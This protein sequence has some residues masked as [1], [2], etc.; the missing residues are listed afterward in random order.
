[1]SYIIDRRLNAKQKSAVNRSRFLRRYRDHIKRAV[2]EAI[3]TRSITDLETGESV[4]IPAKDIHEPTIGHGPGGVRSRV[5]PGNK[6]FLSG[7]HIA[8]PEGGGA[9]G[10][11]GDASDSGEGEDDFVFRITHEEFL[12]YLFDNLELPHLAKKH[13]AGSD[14]VEY[15]RA[16]FTQSGVPA[17]LDIKR[18]MCQSKGRRLAMLGAY[19]SKIRLLEAQLETCTD[20]GASLDLADDIKRLQRRRHAL[21]FLEDMDLRYRLDVPRPVPTSRAVMFCLMGVSGS[22][23][24]ETKNK[25]KRF[26]LL[27]H[28][29][30]RRQYERTE[31]VFIRHHTSAAEVDEHDFF[32]ARETGGTVVSSALQ[33]TDEIIRER[34][35]V[36]DWNLYVAQASDGD[37]WSADTPNCSKLIRE[38]LM[39]LLQYFVYVEISKRPHQ[40]L[41]RA[42]ET[43]SE[44]FSD[45]MALRQIAEVGDIFPVFRGLFERKQA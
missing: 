31:V 4:S 7:D 35:P 23:D 1:M 32:Y 39:P 15:K 34:Y 16:G 3:N 21:P 28:M 13:L 9:G 27:L 10:G 40:E 5:L 36:A 8:R 14:V 19:N 29:F 20:A 17:K 38:S 22:M 41:W 44:S 26:F 43:L 2:D 25:A 33:L 24:Q 37:N 12:H 30:L 42:Y 11:D 6:E 45:K 18:S